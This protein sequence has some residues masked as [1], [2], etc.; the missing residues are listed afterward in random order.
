MDAVHVVATKDDYQF[1]VE[2]F[3]FLDAFLVA[4]PELFVRLDPQ[5]LLDFGEW[6]MRHAREKAFGGFVYR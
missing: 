2:G 5:R 3:E 6:H 4:R 1:W